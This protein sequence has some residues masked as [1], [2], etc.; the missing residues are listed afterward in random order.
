MSINIE[1]RNLNTQ[2]ASA[3][4]GISSSTLAKLRMSPHGAKFLKLGRRVVYRCEDLDAWL[5]ANTHTSTSDG[6]SE[7]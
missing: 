1:K 7:S 5:A 4:T 6:G 2:E 3:Y